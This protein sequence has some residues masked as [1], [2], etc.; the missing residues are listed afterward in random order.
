MSAVAL[1]DAHVLLTGGSRGLG[2]ALAD[3]LTARGARVTLVARPSADLDDVAART[4]SATL[5]LDLTDLSALAGA[6]AKAEAVNGPVDVLIN[7]AAL[8]KL[9]RFVDLE[10]DDMQAMMT[11]N[12]LAPMELSRQAARSMLERDRGMIMNVASLGA[13]V[14]LPNV[15]TYSVSKTGL[16]KFTVDLNGELKRTGVDAVL[17]SLGAV[18]GT[19]M[20]KQ[21][22]DDPI[23]GRFAKRFEALSTPAEDVATRMIRAIEQGRQ[24]VI[25]IPAAARPLVSWSFVPTRAWL[26]GSG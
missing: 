16:V 13:N 21:F 6:V 20:L 7:N 9:A 24:K 11:A 17:V 3:E 26:I 18:G 12:L 23:V 25:V 19:P 10:Q 22:G 4:G 5:P 2:A 14:S 8:A 15:G 1:R